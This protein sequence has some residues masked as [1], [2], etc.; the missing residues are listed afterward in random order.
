M[1]SDNRDPRYLPHLEHPE[2]VGMGLRPLPEACWIETDA[3]LGRYHR[4]KLTQRRRFGAAVYRV[5]PDSLPAQSELAALLLAHLSAEQGEYYRI[6]GDQLCCDALGFVAPLDSS[7]PLWNCSLW[8]ADDVVIMERVAGTYRLTAASLCSPSSWRLE[9]KFNR[10]LA[11]IHAPVPGFMAALAVRVE[12]VFE[13]LRPGQA[14]T[15]STWSLQAGDELAQWPQQRRA[16]SA[17][18]ALYYRAERQSLRRLPQTGAVAFTIRVYVHPLESLAAVPGALPALFRAID[19]APPALARY[20]G[21]DTLAS[22]LSK[23]H[24]APP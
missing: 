1:L 8:I 7:E 6:E 14:L 24:A 20:K 4:H 18:T 10:S 11:H 12:R 13:R 16:I 15:R 17:D 21:F 3:D 5:T 2:I 22:A 19:D 9:E 23:Y